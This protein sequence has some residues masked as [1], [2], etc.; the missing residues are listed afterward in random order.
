LLCEKKNK[1]IKKYKH[2][3]IIIF[4]FEF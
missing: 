1:K 2:I 4:F 3:F